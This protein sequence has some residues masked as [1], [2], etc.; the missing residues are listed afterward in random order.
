MGYVQLVGVLYYQMLLFFTE[1]A[2]RRCKSNGVWENSSDYMNCRPLD[3]NNPLYPDPSIVY[4]SYFYYGGYT[5]SL[6]ALVAAVS[7]FVYFK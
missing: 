6:V 5:I 1:N 7:I 2:S 3:T 4:T